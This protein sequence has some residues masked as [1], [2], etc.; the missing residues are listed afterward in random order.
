MLKNLKIKKT[1]GFTLIELLV[2]IAI[3]G[4][5]STVAVV[6]FNSAR[7]KA[8]DTKCKA[9]LKQILTAIDL[10][11]DQYNTYLIGVTGSGCS[12]CSCRP[13]D[14]ATLNSATCINRMTTTFQNLGFPVA[15][16]D[17]WG[18]FYMMDE[19]EYENPSNPCSNKD[20]LRSLNCGSVDVPFYI[21]Y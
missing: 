10:K 11:R 6:A 1:N 2:V 16:K 5:L 8:K 13:F 4:L 15:L 3:I 19:N 14:E 9:D 18:V 21:C 20:S 12:D 17:P 7:Q